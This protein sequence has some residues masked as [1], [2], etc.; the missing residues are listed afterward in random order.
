M[1]R[2]A[3]I[4]ATGT[5][6]QPVAKMLKEHG[7]SVRVISRNRDKALLVFP[8]GFE[9]SQCDLKAELLVNE[10]SDCYGV[11]INLS[12]LH[13]DIGS[14]EIVKAA[15]KA[16]VQRITTLTGATVCK[17]NTWFSMIERKYNAE[18]AIIKSGIEYC[19]FRPSW[20]MEGLQ[21]F[22][23][24]GKAF[25]FGKQKKEWSLV[26]ARDY[27]L[28]VAESYGNAQCANRIFYA[29]G[30]DRLKLDDALLRYAKT[31][32]PQIEKISYIPSLIVKVMALLSGKKQMKEAGKMMDY[33]NSVSEQIPDSESQ[34]LLTKPS[35][36]FDSWIRTN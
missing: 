25:M 10:F 27:A 16:G 24:G 19:I 7:Y 32:N 12:G 30:P 8:E 13:E 15:V 36:D 21:L 28:M 35:T 20:F 29:Y 26:A 23:R 5:L 22:V 9:I 14:Q 11:H 4:G 33:F 17:E 18:Q 34:L 2:I 31:V 6:G 1:K 3:V